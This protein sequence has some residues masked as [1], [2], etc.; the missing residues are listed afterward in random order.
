MIQIDLCD[1][2]PKFL[3]KVR[4]VGC[5]ALESQPPFIAWFSIYAKT[6]TVER[7]FCLF[8]SMF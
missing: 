4:Y 2:G 3:R 8:R 1:L 5:D 7:G 6:V